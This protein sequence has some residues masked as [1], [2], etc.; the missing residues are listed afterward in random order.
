MSDLNDTHIGSKQQN[1]STELKTNGSGGIINGLPKPNPNNNSLSTTGGTNVLLPPPLQM[2]LQIDA[3]KNGTNGMSHGF[4]GMNNINM[5]NGINNMNMEIASTIVGENGNQKMNK[6]LTVNGTTA[7][8]SNKNKG[9]HTSPINGPLKPSNSSSNL[10]VVSSKSSCSSGS[11]S[12]TDNN[13]TNY[14]LP[15]CRIPY[16]IIHED[17][18]IVYS[19]ESKR[20]NSYVKTFYTTHLKIYPEEDPNNISRHS[21]IDSGLSKTSKKYRQQM[22]DLQTA[23]REQTRTIFTYKNPFSCNYL[24]VEVPKVMNS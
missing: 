13:K 8:T 21:L 3:M 16:S 19:G 6:L 9:K 5:I 12:T 14:T 7:P 10:S 24:E 23:Q 11:S 15:F 22:E 20:I 2:N 1:I 17:P 4:N 18:N